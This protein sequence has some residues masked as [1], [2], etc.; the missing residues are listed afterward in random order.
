M[1][2]GSKKKEEAGQSGMSEKRGDKK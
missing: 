1:K 2:E